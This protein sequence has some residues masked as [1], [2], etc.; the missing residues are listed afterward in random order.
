MAPWL[1]IAAKGYAIATAFSLCLLSGPAVASVDGS[2]VEHTAPTTSLLSPDAIASV[3]SREESDK[4]TNNVTNE[5]RPENVKS[6]DNKPFTLRI[7]PLGASIT[8][9]FKSTD[10]NGYREYFLDMVQSDGWNATMVGNLR[11]GT[12]KENEN[13]G[14]V[15]YRVDQIKAVSKKSLYS[16]KPD[17]ILLNAGTNDGVQHYKVSSTG[18]RMDGF[19]KEIYQASPNTTILFSTLIPDKRAPKAMAD[20]NDQYRKLVAKR[21]KAGDRII[22]AE[23]DYGN[24]T[25][26]DI[27]SDGI[28][29]TDEGY[30]VMADIWYAAF[31]EAVEKGM[32]QAPAGNAT[33]TSTAS[34]S[35]ETGSP[36]D[37]ATSAP[38]Q[39]SKHG[40]GSNNHHIELPF[41]LSIIFSVL[42]LI[43]SF[44]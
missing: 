39:T 16:T 12:M 42:L 19:L 30:H 37:T 17:L 15:G 33:S 5:G 13:N 20:I 18:K 1:V 27:G 29:P 14:Y 25:I 9:G 43:D 10:G 40:V 41:V 34:G 4:S 35:S 32:L 22:L 21:Q 28:H 31:N 36:T 8:Y 26:E 7:M 2:I 6:Q 38:T 24:L 44:V 23:M 11:H 3:Y